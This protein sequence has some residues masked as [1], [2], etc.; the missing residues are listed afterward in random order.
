MI[1]CPKMALANG[2]ILPDLP[3]YKLGTIITYECSKG[4]KLSNQMAERICL[5]NGKWSNEDLEP[6][7]CERNLDFKFLFFSNLI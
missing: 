3:I 2:K 6:F 5:P 7:I 1:T 4:F